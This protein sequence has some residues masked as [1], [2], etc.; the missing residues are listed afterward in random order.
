MRSLAR[1]LETPCTRSD[2]FLQLTFLEL[3]VLQ[4]ELLQQLSES[5]L[6]LNGWYE[7]WEWRR[8]CEGSD[9]WPRW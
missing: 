8:S 7:T 1:P 6:S 5:V 2:F 9:E 3:L 4:L